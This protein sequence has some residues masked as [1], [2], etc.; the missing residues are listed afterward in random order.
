MPLTVCGDIS[1]NILNSCTYPLQAG[2]EDTLILINRSAITNGTVTR[3]GTDN[4]I[5]EN[6]ILPSGETG[7][8][9][10]GVLN[11]HKPQFTTVKVGS[12]QRWSHQIDFLALRTDSVAKQQMQKLKDGDIVAIVYNKFKG[13][14]GKNA[15]E[16]Y[17]FDAGL[18]NEVIKRENN[19][20]DT[21]GAFQITLKTDPDTGLEPFPP[22]S[23]F[24]TSYAAS[25]AVAEGLYTP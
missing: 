4:E 10:Q 9:Y 25:L 18:K 6:I 11:S 12:F 17:G 2:T 20:A 16:I 22:K 19:S 21:Q 8:V 23:L 3:N 7:Y 5:I 24:I 14:T 1:A 13:D 15:F